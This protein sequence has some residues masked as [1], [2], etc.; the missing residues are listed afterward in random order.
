MEYVITAILVFGA[1]ISVVSLIRRLL[2]PPQ[3]E[4]S[5]AHALKSMENIAKEHPAR[6]AE[7]FRRG[8]AAARQEVD[9]L[10]RATNFR[11]RR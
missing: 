2:E 5:T 11:S 1:V 7:A 9:H 6:R 3:I 10:K 8:E 4:P